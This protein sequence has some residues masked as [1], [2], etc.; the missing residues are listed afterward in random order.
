LLP[1]ETGTASSHFIWY[2]IDAINVIPKLKNPLL[3]DPR[4]PVVDVHIDGI[5]KHDNLPCLFAYLCHYLFPRPGILVLQEV[6]GKIKRFF[7][8][9]ATM[10]EIPTG[11]AE[12][13]ACRRIMQVYLTRIGKH[14][15]YPAKRI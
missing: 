8:P 14:E 13:M 2:L 9:D 7:N 15:F 1:I 4:G 3:I 5:G 6:Y 11:S 12:Q 10:T